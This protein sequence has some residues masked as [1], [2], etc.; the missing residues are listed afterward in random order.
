MELMLRSIYSFTQYLY[1]K[2]LIVSLILKITSFSRDHIPMIVLQLSVR[3]IYLFGFQWA[4]TLLSTLL[5]EEW[6]VKSEEWRGETPLEFLVG[7]SG[8]EPPTS[9]LS[10]TRSNLLSYEPM[11]L[12]SDFLFHLVSF[13]S[14]NGFI[15][16]LTCVGIE[17]SSRTVSRK[18][19]SPLQSLT[20]VFGMGTGG[21]SAIKTLTI[22]APASS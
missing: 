9:C 2:T 5:S 18:V 13:R 15:R 11:W 7:P 20:S 4:F 8:L 6:K 14:G 22:D 10:G 1:G 21:P 17:L 12:V 3:F 16:S 19:F